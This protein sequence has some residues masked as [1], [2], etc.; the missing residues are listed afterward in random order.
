MARK[1]IRT[2]KT[3]AR[4]P[5]NLEIAAALDMLAGMMELAGE[6]KYKVIAVQAG[7]KQAAETNR[8]LA[9]IA[10]EGELTGL[11][12]VGEKIAAK[13]EELL[14]TGRLAEL[15]DYKQR[16]PAELVQVQKAQ[17]IGPKT[18]RKVFEA[19]GASNLDE[20]EKAARE[21][22]IAGLPGLGKKAEENILSAIGRLKARGNRVLLG[23]ALPAAEAAIAT[24]MA[25]PEAR[26][27]TFAGSVR[28][29]RE[30]VKDVD[31]I[32][33]ATD[34]AALTEAFGRQPMAAEVAGIGPTKCTIRT[35]T[36]LQIDLRVVP[37]DLYGNLLQHF[38]GSKDHNVSIR[39]LAIT[40][41]LKVSEYG[42][43]E[44]KSGRVHKCATESEVYSLLG[45]DYIEPELREN[46]GEIEAAAAG[47]LPRLIEAADIRGDM[48]LHSDWSDGHAS[49][50][51][52]ALAAKAAGH[53]YMAISDHTQSLGMVQGLTPEKLKRQLEEVARLNEELKG[54]YIFTSCECD[55][56]ADA[57]LDLPDNLLA[58]LDFV[59][60]S[61]HSGFGQKPPQLL[62][63]LRT[64]M[65]N[66]YVRAIGHPTGRIINRREP[67]QVDIEDIISLAAATGTALEINSHYQRLD[68][69]DRHARAAQEAGVKLVINSDAHTP[70]GLDLK[71]GIAT[72][73]RGW[74]EPETVLNTLTLGRMKKLLAKPKQPGKAR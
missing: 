74:I 14:Q 64:A 36:G 43:Q 30:T 62:K 54:F 48:H 8:S 11:P 23:D 58:L 52:M 21:G 40:K 13:I 19:L 9:A 25:L 34:P 5:A 39:E 63:R 32:A 3:A 67:Y 51:E 22:K 17:G 47:R 69:N 18:A 53:N 71:Y 72:A 26:N 55:V 31:I 38:T 41:D 6:N 49:I 27:V 35:H 46:S 57:T 10:A 56:K 12:G 65:E 7:A 44:S 66:P 33:T 70:G 59:T 45:L 29:M 24:L 1:T 16:F 28:R 61:I 60:V 20:F 15:E 42:V 37:D 50:R 73:R 68:L 2:K 4:P